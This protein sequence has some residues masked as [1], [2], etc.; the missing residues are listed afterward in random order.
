MNY[1]KQIE[2]IRETAKK[3]SLD[4]VT[5][6]TGKNGSGKSLIRKLVGFYLAEK[7]GLD[8]TTHVA[9]A[10][11][12][13]QRTESRPEFSAF[14]SA[15]HDDATNPTSLETFEHI[16]KLLKVCTVDNKRFLVVDEPEI[17]MGEEMVAALV[18]WLN[19][20]FNPIPEN[21]YGVLV[22]THNR[23]IVENLK[24]EFLNLEGMTREEWLKRK[25][26]PV[27]L[28]EFATDS[29]ELYRAIQNEINKK[30]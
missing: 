29:L 30:K 2:R 15:M 24:S 23:Y 3:V 1:E 22:I 6:L 20:I 11:S 19:K 25:I 10:T 9:A 14:S 16:K 17:G 13:Q 4:K 12:L 21:C 7:L 28:E 5:V 26:V 27:I 8:R 18:D